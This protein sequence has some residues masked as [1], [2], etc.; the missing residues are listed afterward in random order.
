M[1]CNIKSIYL[2]ATLCTVATFAQ[3]A[4]TQTTAP[5]AYVYVSNTLTGT[6]SE[7]TAYAASKNGKL[8]PIS[9]SPF[10]ADLDSMSVNGK[11]LFGSN[12]NGLYIDTYTIEADGS[13]RYAAATDIVNNNPNGCG[14]SGPLFLDH[15]GATLYDLEFRGD[16]ANNAYQSFN[17]NKPTGQLQNLGSSGPNAWLTLPATFIGN[18]VYGYSASCLGDMYWG[19]YSFK[20]GSNGLLTEIDANAA[21][22]TPP[23]GYFYCPS[24]AA[25]DPT[26]HVAITMQPVNQSNFSPDR[27][28]QLASYTADAAGDLVTTNTDANMPQTLVGTVNVINMAPSG[29]LLAVGGS[30][31][32]QVF[33]FNGSQPITHFTGLLTTASIDQFFWD[34]TNHLYAISNAAGKLYVFTV[35]PTGAEQAPGSP[36]SIHAPHNMIVQPMPRY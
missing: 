8:S 16:C 15:T 29:K 20:R 35:T 3:V 11:Y 33:H 13:L 36:Y 25:A 10:P 7:V 5:V 27:P 1:N 30:K 12:S 2:S 26:N 6:T 32:L 24:Q 4:V 28:A 9:G 18:D 19:I 23:T 17:V 31:G 34:N 22:P 14:N 21:P